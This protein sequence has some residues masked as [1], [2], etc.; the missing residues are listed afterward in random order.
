MGDP[1]EARGGEPKHPDQEFSIT[2]HLTEL[3]V[4]QQRPAPAHSRTVLLAV[5]AAILSRSQP[6]LEVVPIAVKAQVAHPNNVTHQESTVAGTPAN[7]RT[8]STTHQL[9]PTRVETGRGRSTPL[10]LPQCGKKPGDGQSGRL[11]WIVYVRVFVRVS[12]R[13]FCSL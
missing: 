3:N 1:Q 2:L 4:A 13:F 6:T 11:N 12:G 8:H 7:H 5:S 10:N 9:R